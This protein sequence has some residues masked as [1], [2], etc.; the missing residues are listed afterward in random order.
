MKKSK[1]RKTAAV[2]DRQAGDVRQ[3]DPSSMAQQKL[4]ALRS[5]DPV[6][7]LRVS[8]E[9]RAPDLAVSSSVDLLGAM[10]FPLPSQAFRDG[11]FRKKAVHSTSSDSSNKNRIREIVDQ[12]MFG[13]DAKSIFTETSSDS[14]FVWL[15]DTTDE[16][17]SLRGSK[18]SNSVP[19][20]RSV[21]ISDPDTAFALHSTAGHATY[22][23]APPDLE[24]LLVS[25]MLRETRLGCGQYDPSGTS[26]ISMGRGEVEVFIGTAGHTTGWHTD[27]QE[28]F[29]VQL[30]GTKKWTLRQGTV[31]YPLR[32]CTPHYASPD[33]VESQL[34]AAR[35]SNPTFQF[36]QQ[37]VDTNGFGD[38]DTV[39]VETGDVLYFPAGMWHK[40]ETIEPGVSVNISLMGM[41]YATLV[42]QALQ[43]L[44]LKET[45]W[46]ETVVGTIPGSKALPETVP[47][48]I[49]KLEHLLNGLP[50]VI[51]KLGSGKDGAQSILPPALQYPPS[52]RL[53]DESLEDNVNS[54][55]EDQLSVD[56]GSSSKGDA[57]DDEPDEDD[58]DENE[59]TALTDDTAQEVSLP[60]S[61]SEII[62]AE[63]FQGPNG[64]SG[65]KPDKDFY[66]RKNPLATLM[67]MSN[68]V[69]YYG[70]RLSRPANHGQSQL[71]V[72][73]VNFAGNEMH[74]S[75]VRVLLRET[76]EEG[77]LQTCVES[78]CQG[79]DPSARLS[80]TFVSS[81]EHG[82]DPQPCKILDCLLFYGYF[83]W[84]KQ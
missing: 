74:E 50:D 34:K 62:H 31:Q 70:K 54:D 78:E 25:T 63:S 44:L 26:T 71:F 17:S 59:S 83:H 35:L 41:N 11:C 77:L 24:Q 13:L 7:R 46:R 18:A 21:E 43:H 6:L 30:S 38:E 68:I 4:N 28:N 42:C 1:R 40:V 52:F 55:N 23:R 2:M 32:G 51:K 53:D 19:L 56:N 81:L 15:T 20:I 5:Q 9:D 37:H 64:W 61:D 3:N 10:V 22:C 39:V 79:V 14:I 67:K 73:N 29:T 8:A 69:G 36:D 45:A 16:S 27:F 75:A 84:T 72:L 65:Q 82:E 57:C 80:Q 58:N 66:L 47:S 48:A 33:T 76:G 12:Y 60:D 49:E